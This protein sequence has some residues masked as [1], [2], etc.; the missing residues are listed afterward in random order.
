MHGLLNGIQSF[1]LVIPHSNHE[2]SIN[3]DQQN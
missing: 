1:H 2:Y 3:F